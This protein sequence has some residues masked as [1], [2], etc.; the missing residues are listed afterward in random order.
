MF[1]QRKRRKDVTLNVTSL[2]D[3]LF[4]LLIFFMLT[5]TFK[6]V[7][8][9]DLDLPE[10]KTSVPG[11]DTETRTI[12]ID[13]TEDGSVY[14]DG[15]TVAFDRVRDALAKRHRERPEAPVLINAEAGV[16]HGQVMR[17]LDLVRDLG[18]GG[19]AFGAKADTTG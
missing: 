15:E 2:I 11:G 7:G 12:E 18:F 19:V 6:R 10:A 9:L 8:E 13:V 1:H 17:L 4:L 16:R 3:V 5:G 14:M